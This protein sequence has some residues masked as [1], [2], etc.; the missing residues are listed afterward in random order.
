MEYIL[1]ISGVVKLDGS[2]N[3]ITN[4]EV[5]MFEDD[6]LASERSEW[7]YNTVVIE[8]V[9]D[10]HSQKE[11]QQ[12]FEWSKKTKRDDVYKV[13]EILVE[14]DEEKIRKYTIPQMFCDSYTESFSASNKDGKNVS[15]GTWR[16]VLKQ[17]HQKEYFE[18]IKVES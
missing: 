2:K 18:K 1:N 14:Q 17:Q 5:K 6:N 12:I 13:V 7:L 4:V 8:G 3:S 10:N 15:S 11:T 9:L 16:L